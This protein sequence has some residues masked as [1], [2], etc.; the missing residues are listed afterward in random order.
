MDAQKEKI[1]HDIVN[2]IRRLYRAVYLESSKMSRQFGLTAPQSGVLRTLA[3]NGPLSSAELSRKLHVTPSNI[4]GVIDRLEKKGVV[5]R[6]RQETDRR[7]SLI[8]LEKKGAEL[9]RKLPDPIENKLIAG[10]ADLDIEK[11]NA[12]GEAMDQIHAIL[13]TKLPAG[14][15]FE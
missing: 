7:L 9:S 1:I 6:V 15:D 12:L 10:L 13:D 5:K 8:T 2:T 14:F 3:K 11:V 4:T